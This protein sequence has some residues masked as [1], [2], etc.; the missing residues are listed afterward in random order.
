MSKEIPTK[1]DDIRGQLQTFDVLNCIPE[2]FFW[3]KIGH[4]AMVYVN[5]ETGQ[6]MVYESTQTGRSD[7]LSGVQ[8]R[9]MREWLAE[10]PGK[11]YL[12]QMTFW[13]VGIKQE[14]ACRAT[15]EKFCARHI[16]KYRG[17]AYPDLKTRKGRWFVAS[18]AIDL[19]WPFSRW[20][21]NKDIDYV[22]FCTMLLMHCLRFCSMV[23]GGLNPAE[24]EPDD[25]RS[26]D[27]DNLCV[28][29]TE[30][31]SIGPEILVEV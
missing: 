15:A 11:V 1:Y 31:I 10:Y 14:R 28:A 18:S 3:S 29:I 12:R 7:K 24:Y 22:L 19:P 6:V 9:P 21:K 17:T 30:G 13:A 26:G 4:T 25:T 20:F 2:G 16:R 23:R 27:G 5:K 8:L